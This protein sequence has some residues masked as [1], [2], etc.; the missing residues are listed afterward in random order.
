[1]GPIIKLKDFIRE[2]EVF[3]DEFKT[4]LNIRT[5]EFVTLSDDDISAAVDGVYPEMESWQDP[6]HF[7]KA[8]DVVTSDDFKSLPDKFE[9]HEYAIMRDFCYSV[10]EDELR[11]RL[12]NAIHGRGAFR[13]FKDLVFEH[14]IRDDWFAFRAQAFKEIAISWLEA[15]ELEY[16]DK[17]E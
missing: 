8:I 3:G 16:L 6:D 10:E 9:I 5:G 15:N 7:Q 14:G 13:Y 12:L 2:M 4:F 11:E 17:Q 1:M